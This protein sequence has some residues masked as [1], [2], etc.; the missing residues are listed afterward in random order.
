MTG[1]RIYSDFADE[2]AWVRERVR[3]D[4]LALPPRERAVATQYVTERLK[5]LPTSDSAGRI[6]PRLGRPVPYAAYW[7]ADAFAQKDRAFIRRMGLCLVYNSLTTTFKDDLL[8]TVTSQAASLKS[9]VDY[10]SNKYNRILRSSFPPTSPF[11]KANRF[12]TEEWAKYD[13]WNLSFGDR[14][15]S[16]PFSG[17][18]LGNSS[19]YF[20]AVVFPVL[21]GIASAS[22]R[23]HQIPKIKRFLKEFSMGWRIFDDLMDWEKDL[24]SRNYNHSSVLLR[25]RNDQASGERLG[26]DLVLSAFLGKEFVS[27]TYGAML[28]FLREAQRSVRVFNGSYLSEFMKE[29][30]DFHQRKRDELLKA[31]SLFFSRLRS[32]VSKNRK[33]SAKVGAKHLHPELL[34]KT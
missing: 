18:F 5:I 17:R 23:E 13:R 33:V 7:F 28:D 16:F 27:D 25:I 30:L 34:T 32:A 9:L 3:E 11:W 19:R 31:G 10:W 15:R 4:L 24:A 6:D 20:V 22:G 1:S 21:A 14:S 8:D 29:Q 26:R 2:I 12:A